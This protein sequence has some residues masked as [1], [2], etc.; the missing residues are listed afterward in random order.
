LRGTNLL[1]D[2]LNCFPQIT[3][4]DISYQFVAYSIPDMQPVNV[5]VLLPGSLVHGVLL[6]PQLKQLIYGTQ[7]ARVV[8]TFLK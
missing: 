7:R 4:I 1:C 2:V 6:K 5:F 8:P 3:S